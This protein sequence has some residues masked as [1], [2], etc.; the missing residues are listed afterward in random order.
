MKCI[1]EGCNSEARESGNY[2]TACRNEN[3]VIFRVKLLN[4]TPTPSSFHTHVDERGALVRCYHKSKAMILSW[5]FW[6]AS[7]VGF[8]I[9]HAFW[10]Y[11]PP[12]NY[13][14]K[15]FGL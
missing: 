6:F 12:F 10:D 14:T 8:P 1:G 5:E 7:M 3:L 9:E 13:L 11:V 15:F 4:T 2:C